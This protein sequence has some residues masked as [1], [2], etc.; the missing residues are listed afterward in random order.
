MGTCERNKAKEG[1]KR[2]ESIVGAVEAIQGRAAAST[3]GRMLLAS[4]VLL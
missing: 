3:P 4:L 2:K 1:D